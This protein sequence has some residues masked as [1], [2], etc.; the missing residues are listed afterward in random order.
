MNR[1][2]IA[3]SSLA[4]SM[5]AFVGL[6]AHEGYTDGAIIPTKNDRPTLGHGS[7]FWEDGR[8]VKMG[9]TITPTRAIQ[10]ASK[11]ITKEEAVF[12]ASIPG[13]ALHQAEYDIYMGWV[14]QFGTGAWTASPMRDALIKGDYPAACAGLKSYKYMTSA[15]A[16]PGWEPFKHDANGRPTRWRFDCSTPNNRICRGVWTRQVE[17]YSAC[18]EA[19]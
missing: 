16:T 13:V 8:P 6:V 3:I 9:E 14:Y 10:L 1:A 17:R 7:T 15:V 4:L 11:H 5:A 18:M 19:Q 2:R 12:R